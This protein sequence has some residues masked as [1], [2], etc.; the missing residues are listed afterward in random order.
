M[1]EFEN[2]REKLTTEVAGLSERDEI[3]K[4]N[5]HNEKYRQRTACFI[6]SIGALLRSS[7]TGTHQ[8]HEGKSSCGPKGRR[9]DNCT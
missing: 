6:R 3:T 4:K 9:K 5:A 8:W 1:T 2:E 7:S